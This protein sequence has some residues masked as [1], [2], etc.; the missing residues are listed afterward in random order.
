MTTTDESP[1]YKIAITGAS[2]QLGA[3]L[4]KELLNRGHSLKVLVHDSTRG[5][6]GLP[7]EIV[8]GSVLN[9]A[10]CEAL[11]AGTDV[12]FHLAAII[13]INGDQ[14]GKVWNVNVNGTRNMLDA[15]VKNKV[16]KL[17]HFSSIHAYSTHPMHEPLDEK[18]P[19]AGEGAFAY[20]KSKAAAQTL[21]M[22][23]VKEHGLNASVI[24]PTGVLGGYDY[25][26][27]VNSQ[28]LI[29]FYHGKVPMLFSGGF[30]WV[31]ARDVVK[32]AIAAMH[33]GGPGE[34]YLVGGKYFTLREFSAVI[35]RVTGKRTPKAIVPMWVLKS[36]LPVVSLYGKI[37]RTEPLYTKEALKSLV[38][39][40]KQI[41]CD[42]ACQQLGHVPRP[43]EET[44]QD[45]YAWFGEQGYL[46]K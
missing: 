14:K 13:S 10:D 4:V 12:V 15:C 8:H 42:K 18:R 25:L 46:K 35:G 28:L 9:P 26:P 19:L 37:T 6:D 23:Y 44:L 45:A 7:V 33:K 21:V 38:E 16:K 31:D 39:G 29:D 17:V 36:A 11:C 30:N 40:N 5:L 22:Q 41:V 1:V 3:T 34:S 32:A 20:E 2:G 24:N 43:I 27:T